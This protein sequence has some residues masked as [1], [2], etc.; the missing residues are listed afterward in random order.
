MAGKELF[1]AKEVQV[2]N[3]GHRLS[4]MYPVSIEAYCIYPPRW[5]SLLFAVAHW[6]WPWIK[7]LGRGYAK[8][9]GAL[10]TTSKS[11]ESL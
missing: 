2:H 3:R 1:D 6:A 4:I 8:S 11:N 7:H 5:V 9:F 10:E